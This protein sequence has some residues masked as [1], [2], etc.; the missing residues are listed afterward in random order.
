MVDTVKGLRLDLERAAARISALEEVVFPRGDHGVD[1]I[2]AHLKKIH[3]IS[4]LTPQTVG[5]LRDQLP[6]DWRDLFFQYGHEKVFAEIADGHDITD[7][8]RH[9]VEPLHG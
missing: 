1:A 4:K 7:A 2:R 8:R 5:F 6:R 9:L 3:H